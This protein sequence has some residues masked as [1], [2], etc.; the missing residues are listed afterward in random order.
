MPKR[1]KID[2]V[3]E[4]CLSTD[5]YLSPIK[6]YHDIYTA[7]IGNMEQDNRV[8]VSTVLYFY[9]LIIHSLYMLYKNWYY[10]L[11]KHYEILRVAFE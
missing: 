6:T 5:R 9:I 11:Q 3:C 1:K 7:L 2:T 4:G 8:S 10:F